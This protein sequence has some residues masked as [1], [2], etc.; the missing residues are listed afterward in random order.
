MKNKFALLFSILACCSAIPATQA[1]TKPLKAL[2]IAGGCCHD[3]KGQ[4]KVLCDGIQVR[5]NVQVDVVWTDDGSTNPPLP[6]Y[7]NPDWAKGYDVII[8]D[9]CAADRK[10]IETT[11]R[12][13]EA[14]KTIPALHLHCA[15]HSFRTGTDKWFRHLGLESNS[16]W[17]Q[18]P[19]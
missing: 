17:P 18:E 2:L 1:E 11:E 15:M 4:H 6:I 8:H 5:A 9:E 14:H 7:D 10:D 16:H 3:Y 13:L 12:I 19:I